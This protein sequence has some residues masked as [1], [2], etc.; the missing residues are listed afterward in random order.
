MDYADGTTETITFAYNYD[1]QGKCT[2]KIV[3][4]TLGEVQ[5]TTYTYI[6]DEQGN[7][8]FKFSEND[9][10]I[11]VDPMFTVYSKTG[12]VIFCTYLTAYSN[13]EISDYK[14]E[15]GLPVSITFSDGSELTFEYAPAYFFDVE[16]FVLPEV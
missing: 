13:K 8:L 3:R 11:Y 10:N 1:E 9:D 15:N 2:E 12:N 7:C 5:T 4:N 14:Y 6:V 16:G